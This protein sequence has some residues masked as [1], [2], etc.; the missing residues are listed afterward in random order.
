MWEEKQTKKNHYCDGE[1]ARLG[2]LFI[3]HNVKKKTLTE[4]KVLFVF[5]IAGSYSLMI[6]TR[7]WYLVT[8]GDRRF[9]HFLSF[10]LQALPL[11]QTIQQQQQDCTAPAEELQ[12]NVYRCC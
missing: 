10:C 6:R 7:P 2:S 8:A 12:H 5:K 4:S 11:S 3:I 9:K 1:R